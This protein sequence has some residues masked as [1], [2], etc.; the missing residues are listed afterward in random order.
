[1]AS[2]FLTTLNYEY[3]NFSGNKFN[4]D[5]AF[6]MAKAIEENQSLKTLNLSNNEFGDRS[7][8][9]FKGIICKY[10]L[11]HQRTATV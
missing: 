9:A 8:P 10:S 2:P 11:N 6:T 5:D 4:D 1:M 3:L 7:G